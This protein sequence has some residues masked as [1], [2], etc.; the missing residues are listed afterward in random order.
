MVDYQIH[1][2]LMAALQ[3]ACTI[4]IV[5]MEKT[6]RDGGSVTLQAANAF[7]HGVYHDH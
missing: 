3:Y 6:G 4:G 1:M 2:H 5:A 7:G